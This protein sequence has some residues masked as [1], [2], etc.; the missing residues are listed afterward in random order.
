MSKLT[1]DL[2]LILPILLAGIALA[3]SAWGFATGSIT[4]GVVGIAASGVLFYR[5]FLMDAGHPRDG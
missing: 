2:P 5:L 3:F 4:L 1:P